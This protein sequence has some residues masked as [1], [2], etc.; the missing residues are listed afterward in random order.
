METHAT[1]SYPTS[2]FILTVIIPN[3]YLFSAYVYHKR[4]EIRLKVIIKC[5]FP[6]Q[7]YEVLSSDTWIE[8]RIKF[9]HT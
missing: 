4:F 9:K 2:L 5:D 1:F 3:A 7:W 6:S 8:F